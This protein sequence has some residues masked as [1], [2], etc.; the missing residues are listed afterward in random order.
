TVDKTATE[1]FGSRRRGRVARI[2]RI[3]FKR[4][5]LELVHWAK[6]LRAVSRT[7]MLIVAGTGIVSDH[8]CGPLAWPY[9]IFKLS[10]LAALCRV[11]LVFL[12]VGV[13]PIRHPLSR[14]FLTRSLALA[15]HRSY[16]D[17]AS[18]QYLEKIG[19]N[20]DR[21]FVY[22]DV[23]F[24]LSQGNL[25]SGVRAGQ[26]RVVGEPRRSDRQI[27][28]T[29]ER[30]GATEALHQGGIGQ[31]SPGSRCAVRDSPYGIERGGADCGGGAVAAHNVNDVPDRSASFQLAR[32]VPNS[33]AWL[34]E[35]QRAGFG[36]ARHHSSSRLLTSRSAIA[37]SCC[38][39][40]CAG[41]IPLAGAVRRRELSETAIPHRTAK[42]FALRR[43]ADR[44]ASIRSRDFEVLSR[45]WIVESHPRLAQLLPEARYGLGEPQSHGA[46]IPA[47]RLN[48]TH[49]PKILQS[50]LMF[51]DRLS[52]FSLE[53]VVD[54]VAQ[55]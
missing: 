44:Q 16:R 53:Q 38:S 33:G 1:R 39:R 49:A 29:G 46:R 24:G 8:V 25:V 27:Q 14:W 35:T 42:I 20:T 31:I 26:K 7:D 11:K 19:F 50:R 41:C 9:D 18:K 34:K 55:A 30:H 48:P 2:C 52:G 40:H 21:D 45:R 51:S 6:S 37:A 4:I 23:V 12:S 28:A 17:E 13:G 22:P 43:N 15:H 32:S 47:S 10:T 54:P 36:A 5:P 3:A